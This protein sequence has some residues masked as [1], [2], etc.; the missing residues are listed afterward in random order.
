M[1]YTIVLNG[2]IWLVSMTYYALF[3]RRWYTGPKVTVLAGSES[4]VM[5]GEGGGSVFPKSE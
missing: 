5:E 1:N 4:R 2:F 3:A